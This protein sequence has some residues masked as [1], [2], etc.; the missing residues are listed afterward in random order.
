MS[1]QSRAIG[2][3]QCPVCKGAGKLNAPK[4]NERRVADN[5]VMA[6]LLH[7]EG[8]SLREISKFLGYKS[9]R[10]AQLLIDRKP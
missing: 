3:A 7:R 1:A 4:K 6:K 5:A 9:S 2:D 8:Y 10:S